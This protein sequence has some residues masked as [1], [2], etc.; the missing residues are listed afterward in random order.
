MGWVC[1]I[2]L[3]A[4]LVDTGGSGRILPG[5]NLLQ[6]RLS[7]ALIQAFDVLC[8]GVFSENYGKNSNSVKVLVFK[9]NEATSRS[10]NSCKNFSSQ[11]SRFV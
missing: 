3:S 10:L 1:C 2:E 8:F 9:S 11:I 6:A 4:K 5:E 7:S